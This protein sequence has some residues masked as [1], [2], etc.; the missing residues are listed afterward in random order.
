[1]VSC[2]FRLENLPAEGR[3]RLVQWLAGWTKP[4]GRVLIGYVNK[5]SFHDLTEWMRGRRGGPGGVEYVLAPD[6]NIGPFESL[7]PAEV[8]RLCAQAGLA[9]ESRLGCQAVPQRDEI[10]F[11]ARNFSERGKETARGVGWLLA[12]IGKLPG[13]E[14][15]RGRFQFVCG[16][17][18]P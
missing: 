3:V 1:M 14:Q 5:H 4:G 17:K 11:R 9:I 15:R 2:F 16:R 8:E 18:R 10:E 6:P 12:R 7:E 13:I